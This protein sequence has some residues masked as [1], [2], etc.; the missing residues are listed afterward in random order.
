MKLLITWNLFL[1][2]CPIS[3]LAQDKFFPVKGG[4]YYGSKNIVVAYDPNTYQQGEEA[5]VLLINHKGRIVA[6]FPNIEA[7]WSWNNSPED[8]IYDAEW[9]ESDESEDFQ[10]VYI[11][12]RAGHILSG[13]RVYQVTDRKIKPIS[14]SPLITTLYGKQIIG[15]ESISPNNSGCHPIKWLSNTFMRFSDATGNLLHHHFY[16]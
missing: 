2:V 12:Y 7:D 11:R 1:F 3:I 4:D 6:E 14:F 9:S 16:G 15:D 13:F 10:Y 5:K 8:V